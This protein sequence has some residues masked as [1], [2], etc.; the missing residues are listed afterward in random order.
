M[1]EEVVTVLAAELE[2]LPEVML[3]V[4]VEDV[5]PIALEPVVL[6]V[7]SVEAVLLIL[8]TMEAVSV[9]MVVDAVEDAII[10]ALGAGTRASAGSEIARPRPGCPNKSSSTN[11]EKWSEGT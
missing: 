8:V 3:E 4:V 11:N 10:G 5:D 2:T 9:E 1:A 6:K 7:A